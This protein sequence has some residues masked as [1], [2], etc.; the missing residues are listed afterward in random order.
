MGAIL[1]DV[2]H[3][4]TGHKKEFTQDI[5]AWEEASGLP[6]WKGL[7]EHGRL[8]KPFKT[9]GLFGYDPRL[10]LEETRVKKE[11]LGKVSFSEIRAAV[12]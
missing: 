4:E 6:G 2:S 12:K 1:S 8:G 9:S 11:G 7:P 3:R 5:A 10:F